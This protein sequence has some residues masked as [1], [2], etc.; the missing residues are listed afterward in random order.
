VLKIDRSFIRDIEI[1]KNS[2]AIAAAIIALAHNL[3]LDVV[4]EGVEKEEQ[5]SFLKSKA[6][7]KVQGFLFSKPV[8][9]G[10]ID[11]ILKS[12]QPY[13]RGDRRRVSRKS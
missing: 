12:K 9:A 11:E 1:N 6:C 13:G 7:D 8:P 2:E 3:N 5:L 10:E 4:A